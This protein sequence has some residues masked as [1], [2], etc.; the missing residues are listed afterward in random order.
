MTSWILVHPNEGRCFD[1][2]TKQGNAIPF[3]V[4]PPLIWVNVTA[5]DVK[6][7]HSWSA[8]LVD[9]SWQFEPPYTP[10]PEQG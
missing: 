8:V 4:A 5:L 1:F 2:V 7:K 3:P 6:P 10:P 9:D